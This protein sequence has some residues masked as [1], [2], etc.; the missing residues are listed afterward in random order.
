VAK[1]STAT[2]LSRLERAKTAFGEDSA[3]VKLELLGQLSDRPLVGPDRVERFHECLCFLLAYPDDRRVFRRTGEL[4]DGFSRRSDLRRHRRRL[5]NSGIAGTDVV[6]PFYW[7]TARWLARRWPDVLSIAWSEPFERSAELAE[8][9]FLLVPYTETPALDEVG[10]EL[11]DWLANLKGPAETDAVFLIRRFDAVEMDPFAREKLY[12]DFDLPL[13][14]A[15]GADT[16]SRSR[17]R[18][19]RAPLAFQQAPLDRARPVLAREVERPPVAVREVRPREAR[20]LVDLTRGAMV[21]RSRDLD[22]FANADPGD[23][24]IVDLERGYQFAVIGVVPERRLMFESAYG[25]LT[26]KNGVP[27]GY[28]LVTA[29][30]GSAGIAYNVFDTYRG[31]E[32]GFVFGRLL[33]TVRA[34]FGV[35]A[36]SIDPYQLGHGNREGLESGAWWFYYKLGFRPLDP[37]VR[38][39]ARRELARMKSDPSHRSSIATLEKLSAE[40]LFWHRG[41]ARAD[42]LGRLDLGVAGL[43]VSRYLAERFGADRERGIAICAREAARV[44]GLRSLARLSPGERLAWERWGP[45]VMAMPRVGRWPEASRRALAAVIRAKG[46]RRESDFVARFDAHARLRR[47]IL[48]LIER[49]GG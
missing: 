41:R 46:G 13:A 12:D 19:K 38:K 31:A 14:L 30:F 26:L 39:L 27:L 20:R 25:L 36:W 11:E 42:V 47:A 10:Y 23:V 28:A 40:Y 6:Y 45:V 35:D 16:P 5:V 3:T 1:P 24:R 32:A 21:T 34:L 18:W 9:L 49:G 4:L 29:L 48:R 15:P 37:V 33:A 2:L 8:S 22:V 43:A 17:A 44:L 7:P